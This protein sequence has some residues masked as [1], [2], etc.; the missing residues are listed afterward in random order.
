MRNLRLAPC[1]RLVPLLALWMSLVVDISAASAQTGPNFWSIQLD[2]GLFAPSEATGK[3]PSFGMR[4]CKHY[5]PHSQGGLRTGFTL[6]STSVMAPAT[7][8]QSGEAQ[9][10]LARVDARLVPLM[11]FIQIN[12]TEKFWLV[13]LVGI[14]AGYE[15]LS[16]DSQDHRTGLESTATFGNVAW[17][18]YGGVALRVAPMVRLNGEVFYNGGSLERRV[19][20]AA[21]KASQTSIDTVAPCEILRVRRYLKKV[22]PNQ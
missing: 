21:A 20:D 18:T 16:L 10:E 7:G 2:G 1:S 9:V 8:L 4:Y 11:G 17:E 5:S 19:T 15:W 12:L 22:E 3:S 13:P 6:K 14:G